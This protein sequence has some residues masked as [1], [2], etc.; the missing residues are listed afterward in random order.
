MIDELMRMVAIAC[1]CRDVGHPEFPVKLRLFPAALAM[2]V[3]CIHDGVV[4]GDLL[5]QV[6]VCSCGV[7]C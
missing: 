4:V 5:L 6:G 3:M 7:G 2:S 1:V